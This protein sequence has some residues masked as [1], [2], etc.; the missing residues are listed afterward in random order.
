MIYSSFVHDIC[1]E[2]KWHCHDVKNRGDEFHGCNGLFNSYWSDSV[3]P[4]EC[5]DTV[6][7][8]CCFFV[9]SFMM[10]ETVNESLPASLWGVPTL[11]GFRAGSGLSS[12]DRPFHRPR[13]TMYFCGNGLCMSVCLYVMV[14]MVKLA[15]TVCNFLCVCLSCLYIAVSLTHVRE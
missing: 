15:E 3:V 5:V 7:I 6:F 11:S 8:P 13:Q 12:L 2:K 10:W 14:W 9:Y 1:L 4:S